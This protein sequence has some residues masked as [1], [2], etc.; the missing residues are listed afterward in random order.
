VGALDDASL[1]RLSEA[2]RAARQ[3][4]AAELAAAGDKALALVPRL[5]RGPVRK[6][7]GS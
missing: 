5:L 1:T 6:M 4:Q 3:R 2:V 7:F